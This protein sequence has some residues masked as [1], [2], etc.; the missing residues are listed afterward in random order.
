MRFLCLSEVN[1]GDLSVVSEK[2]YKHLRRAS[3]V[4]P[5]VAFVLVTTLVVW[6]YCAHRELTTDFA[7][8]EG[9]WYCEELGFEVNFDID[10]ANIMTDVNGTQYLFACNSRSR[11][12]EVYTIADLFPIEENGKVRY[13]YE[14]GKLVY[15]FTY[16]SLKGNRYTIQDN[17]GNKYVFVRK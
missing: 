9:V 15:E 4:M 10:R 2:K 16:V 6:L 1:M 3:I 11:A 5:I 13:W 14:Y 17:D 8:N 7:P 12:V